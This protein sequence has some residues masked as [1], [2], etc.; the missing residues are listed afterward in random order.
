M[1]Q[2]L[3]ALAVPRCVDLPIGNRL[4]LSKSGYLGYGLTA[5]V[6][7]SFRRQTFRGMMSCYQTANSSSFLYRRVDPSIKMAGS[8]NMG[9]FC[10]GLCDSL[11]ATKCAGVFLLRG[12]LTSGP[13]CW[14]Q[15]RGWTMSTKSDMKF[16]SSRSGFQLP[17]LGAGKRSWA[18]M[19]C[20][21]W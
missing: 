20:D 8:F 13:K 21:R 6:A 10:L 18:P 14:E 4:C 19:G 1:S 7:W 3:R 12:G 9:N 16:Q 2:N 5:A 15:L 11:S 17:D